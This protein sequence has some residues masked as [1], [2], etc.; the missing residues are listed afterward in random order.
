[1][2]YAAG[3]KTRFHDRHD[4]LDYLKVCEEARRILADA[5]LL[6]EARRYV[7]T[8]MLPD[9]HQRRYGEMWRDLL[10]QP[11]STVAAALA[12]DSERAQL[13]RD[14]R[15]PFGR[16]LTAQDV[17]ALLDRDRAATL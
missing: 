9:P 11:A 17:A 8:V 7:E 15:P 1:L 12:E 14:T 5:S 3:M 10:R 16:G 6:D 2:R 4:R 13:L